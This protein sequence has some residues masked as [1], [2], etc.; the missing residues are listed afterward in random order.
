MAWEALVKYQDRF[1]MQPFMEDCR[2]MLC[3]FLETVDQHLPQFKE[4]VQFAFCNN[5][6]CSLSRVLLKGMIS[7]RFWEG[8]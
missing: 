8:G 6:E 5:E 2:P 4:M 7:W 3:S 1:L